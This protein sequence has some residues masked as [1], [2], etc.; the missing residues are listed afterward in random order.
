MSKRG[1]GA[2]IRK[3]ARNAVYARDNHTCHYCGIV[4]PAPELLP[5]LNYPEHG[6]HLTLDHIIPR[7][8]GG[9]NNV[10]N[11]VTA[12][13]ECNNERGDREYIEFYSEM[14]ERYPND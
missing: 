2:K 12:C 8:E 5:E 11:L 7:S 6:N 3:N 4:L 10:Y 1:P 9:G 14:K 13:F